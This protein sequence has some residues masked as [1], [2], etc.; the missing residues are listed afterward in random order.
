MFKTC[1]GGI[2]TWCAVSL[3]KTEQTGLMEDKRRRDRLKKVMQISS[4]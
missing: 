4:I 3:K 1:H 2:F